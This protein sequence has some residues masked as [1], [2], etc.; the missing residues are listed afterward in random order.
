MY[1]RM[2]VRMYISIFALLVKLWLT[3]QDFDVTACYT[4][5]ILGHMAIYIATFIRY[6]LQHFKFNYTVNNVTVYI[7]SSEYKYS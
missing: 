6:F 1:V 4:N 3:V 7:N 2:R 5:T